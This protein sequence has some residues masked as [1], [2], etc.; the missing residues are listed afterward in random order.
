M[1]GTNIYV[2]GGIGENSILGDL[3]ILN[4]DSWEWKVMKCEGQLPCPRHSHSLAAIGQK[5]YLFGGRDARRALGDFHILCLKTKI[6]T[7][8]KLSGDLSAPRF[9]HSMTTVGKWLVV[10]GGCPIAKHGTDLILF[11]VEHMVSKRISLMPALSDVLLVRHSATFTGTKLVIIGGGAACFA[12]GAK[13]NPPFSIDLEPILKDGNSTTMIDI[14]TGAGRS[15]NSLETPGVSLLVNRQKNGDAESTWVLLLDKNRAKIGKDA[16]KNVGWLDQTRKP[17]VLKEGSH[18]AFPISETGALFLQDMAPNC[19][20]TSCQRPSNG[21]NQASLQELLLKL[22]ASG[23][24]VVE[25]QVADATKRPISP[26]STLETDVSSLLQ[27]VGLPKTLLEELPKRY[28]LCSMQHL[29]TKLGITAW[30]TCH[31]VC[32]SR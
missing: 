27:E 31:V 18:V 28:A 19:A 16:L 5:L 9:S 3:C 25:M 1:V 29:C 17:K 10:L 24:E 11:D 32:A 2:F 22:V 6:W 7:E 14:T 20:A 12:F 26:L 15:S 23:G 4:S 8:V 13:F 21:S 30:T